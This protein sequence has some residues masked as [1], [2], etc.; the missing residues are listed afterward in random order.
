M[1]FE[2]SIILITVVFLLIFSKFNKNV[3][4]VYGLTFLWIL[5]FEY[6]TQALWLNKNLESWAYLYLDVSWII[7]L[8]WT[9]IIVVAREL[10]ALYLSKSDEKIRLLSALV[11]IT[12]V[13]LFA[14]WVVLKLGIREYSSS[15]LNTVSGIKIGLV[16]V[17]AIYYIPVFMLL[18]ITFTLYW[19]KQL[20]H[21][22][23]SLTIERKVTK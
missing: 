4:K 8:G 21:S 16:P 13:G 10:S 20:F 19:E 18:V 11:I 9:T 1:I 17:E 15:V 5:L 12:V 2:I 6:F 23:D 7:T 3:L 22:D 14:E